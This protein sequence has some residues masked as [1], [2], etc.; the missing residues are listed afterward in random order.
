MSN[1]WSLNKWSADEWRKWE[2][3]QGSRKKA[4]DKKAER[5]LEIQQRMA[6]LTIHSPVWAHRSPARSP[7]MPTAASPSTPTSPF[8]DLGSAAPSHDGSMDAVN[9]RKQN[10]ERIK[11]LITQLASMGDNDPVRPAME[12]ALSKAKSVASPPPP[13]GLRLDQATRALAAAQVKAERLRNV[14][15]ESTKAADEADN[16]VAEATV[17][18]DEAKAVLHPPPPPPAGDHQPKVQVLREAMNNIAAMGFHT[19]PGMEDIGPTLNSLWEVIHQAL[20]PTNRSPG[21]DS[22]AQ[23]HMTPT[24]AKQKSGEELLIESDS[25][26]SDGEFA[27]RMCKAMERS[28]LRKKLRLK[29]KTSKEA[30][31]EAG[32]NSC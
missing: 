28:P 21:A 3:K 29:T 32:Y 4:I 22:P 18:L 14:A 5:E 1:H 9:K 6:E 31:M 24:K 7:T 17:E 16:A 15:I 11:W 20:D 2:S 27:Q 25:E 23:F 26:M 8:S 10:A 12:E 19:K 30:C 13:P